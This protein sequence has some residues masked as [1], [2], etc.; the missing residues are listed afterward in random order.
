MLTLARASSIF[1][2]RLSTDEVR[3]KP[4][5]ALGQAVVSGQG[6]DSK[7]VKRRYPV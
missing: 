7:F 3:S 1:D 4:A 5:V 6:D 2:L